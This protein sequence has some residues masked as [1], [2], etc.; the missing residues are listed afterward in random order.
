MLVCI[1]LISFHVKVSSLLNPFNT[2]LAEWSHSNRTL[3]VHLERTLLSMMFS[4]VL[5]M[6]RQTERFLISSTSIAYNFLFFIFFFFFFALF[7]RTWDEGCS[8]SIVLTVGRTDWWI[9][10]DFL[11][12]ISW[13]IAC[14][15]FFLFFFFFFLF[16]FFFF[17]LGFSVVFSSSFLKWSGQCSDKE[18]KDSI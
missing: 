13:S 10:I 14:F 11:L 8:F 9:V 4:T 7:L 12:S 16:F 1:G 2:L 3:W 15:F 17:L 18:V 5:A 6:W